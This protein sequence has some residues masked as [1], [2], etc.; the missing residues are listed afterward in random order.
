MKNRIGIVVGFFLTVLSLP[1]N[2]DP[3]Y[4]CSPQDH[5]NL[6]NGDSQLIIMTHSS[7]PP[8]EYYLMISSHDVENLCLVSYLEETNRSG[9]NNIDMDRVRNKLEC[10][11][12]GCYISYFLE[13]EEIGSRNYKYVVKQGKTKDVQ[14]TNMFK[15][16]ERAKKKQTESSVE[17]GHYRI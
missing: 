15:L 11:T 14:L 8:G 2:A 12:T 7:S 4:F 10:Y 1:A 5:D 16:F 3:V 17:N 13:D 6:K 9:E